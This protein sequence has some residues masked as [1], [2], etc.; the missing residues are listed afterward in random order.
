MTVAGL[1]TCRQLGREK[2]VVLVLRRERGNLGFE[3]REEI[4]EGRTG[5]EECT[6]AGIFAALAVI[7][8]GLA[9]SGKDFDSSFCSLHGEMV[10]RGDPSR[11]IRGS[12]SG[13]FRR[14]GR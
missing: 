4:L 7:L 3:A 10:E 11:L 8:L 12:L 5:D 14:G 6:E 13:F 2:W 9:V 1:L